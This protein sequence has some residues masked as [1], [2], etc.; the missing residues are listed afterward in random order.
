MTKHKKIFFLLIT[1]FFL[2]EYITYNSVEQYYS[3]KKNNI[4][5][6]A[7]G[8]ISSNYNTIYAILQDESISAFEGYIN[9]DDVKEAFAKRDRKKLYNL[10]KEKYQILKNTGYKQVHFH[11]PD[12]HSFLRMHKPESY[13][14]DLSAVR[15]TVVYVNKYHKP[16]H[17][18]EIG[19]VLPGFRHVYPVFYQNQYIGSAEISFGVKKIE[20]LLE[21]TYS[22]TSRFLIKKDLFDAIVFQDDKQLYTVSNENSDYVEINRKNDAKSKLIDT[23]TFDDTLQSTI[24]KQM[25]TKK[26]FAFEYDL[27]VKNKVHQHYIVIFLPLK[28][29]IKQNNAFFVFYIPNN[30]LKL[31]ESELLNTHIFTILFL[32][33][34]FLVFLVILKNLEKEQEVKTKITQEKRKFKDILANASDGIHIVDIK[35]NLIECSDSFA[36]SLGYTKEEVL[37]LNV[38]D[39]DAKIN[40]NSILPTIDRLIK[41]PKAFQTKHRKKDGN[42]IDVQINA[43]KIELEGTPYLYASSRDISLET[44]QRKRLQLLNLQTEL[45]NEAGKVG[46]FIDYLGKQKDYWSKSLKEIFEINPYHTPSRELAF[47]KIHPDDVKKTLEQVANVVQNRTMTTT[48]FR[49]VQND[50]TI[51]HV[52]ATFKYFSIDETQFM[53]GTITDISDIITLQERVEK[54]QTLL[55]ENEKMISLGAMIG[56]IAHQWRQPLSSISIDATGILMKKEM[57]MLG[58]NELETKLENINNKAQYLSKTIDIFKNFIKGTK[59]KE[60]TT[61][62]NE[63]N[64][65]YEIVSSSLVS[66]YIKVNFKLSSQTISVE[67]NA[68]ELEQVLINIL[69]N[70]KDALIE[71]KVTEPT[72]DIKLEQRNNYGV[73]TIEDNAEGIP[74]DVLPKIFEPYFTTKHQSQG[75]GLGLHM[76]HKIIT[77]S[78]EG[79]IEVT[80]T[81]KG[82]LFTISIPLEETKNQKH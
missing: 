32:F 68:G 59:E 55:Y 18:L 39:W 12:N 44:K 60:Q 29:F 47:S 78:L 20:S 62:Q 64:K 57:G 17:G 25:N 36:S 40:Q 45:A 31:I 4:L 76:A 54:Q 52:F 73:I 74:D 33:I 27:K 38:K 6:D 34:L 3:D 67:L 72:I 81:N 65:A 63:I 75:T 19:K 5:N 16:I 1:L 35:G 30:N 71:K 15:N 22:F 9:R 82:A 66:H 13:G 26:P 70:A 23:I 8:D 11:T 80:N 50:K 61:L 14:D 42:I 79:K 53:A 51:K 43:K 46:I 58:D 28:N 41:E 69:N 56:N 48:Q 49:I 10:L 77:Q 21:K 24:K 37:K 2:A 7:I